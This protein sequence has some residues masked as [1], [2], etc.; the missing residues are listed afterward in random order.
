MRPGG[1][2]EEGSGRV[3]VLHITIQLKRITFL[4]YKGTLVPFHTKVPI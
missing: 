2:N 1:M 3:I 4:V